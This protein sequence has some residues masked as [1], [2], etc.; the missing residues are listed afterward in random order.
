MEYRSNDENDTLAL[1]A[2]LAAKCQGG[3]VFAL[4]G[5]LGAG[6]T[7]F[8]KGLAAGLGVCDTVTSPT[9]VIM[10]VY[11]A[12]LPG[13]GITRFVHIDAYRLRSA[14]D[15]D[16]IGAPEYIGAPDT[17]TVI[18]WAEKAAVPVQKTKSITISVVEGDRR[19]I[20]V[21]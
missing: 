11:P 1:A 15:L 16:A 9:F 13:T 2:S 3:E 19:N 4:S 18:E 10:K 17:V 20:I 6:K 12:T 14:A 21:I 8:A 5:P 7:V